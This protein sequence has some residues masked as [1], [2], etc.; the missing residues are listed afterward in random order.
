MVDLGFWAIVRFWLIATPVELGFV[1]L[2]AICAWI[3]YAMLI[4]TPKPPEEADRDK[5]LCLDPS[6]SYRNYTH[7]QSINK[8]LLTLS[9]EDCLTE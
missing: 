8:K 9:F 4:T 3:G 6:Y 5:A 2:L 7:V 1:V